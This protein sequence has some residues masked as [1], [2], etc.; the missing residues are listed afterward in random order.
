MVMVS[1]PGSLRIATAGSGV[2][3]AGAL[4]PDLVARLS[5]EAAMTAGHM[6]TM[7]VRALDYCPPVDLTFGDYLRALVTADVQIVPEDRLG[8]RTAVVEA[9]RAWGVYPKGL[10]ALAVDT[11]VWD[12][13]SPEIQKLLRPQ[14]MALQPY[15]SNYTYLS[16]RDKAD[17]RR[18]IFEK[19]GEWR[20]A[21]HG[22]ITEFLTS[23]EA[24]DRQALAEEMGID[25][26][27]GYASF[28]LRALQFT[29]KVSPDGNEVPQALL[30]FVQERGED[31]DGGS[32]AF[33]FRGG[34][35]VIVDLLSGEIDY[36]IRKNV[37]S[38]SR[39]AAERA[40]H[41]QARAGLVGMYLGAANESDPSRQLALLHGVD[42][43]F[44]HG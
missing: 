32:G 24:T 36:V 25:L 43:E 1:S 29:R 34:C 41:V 38:G 19:L 2:L 37:R 12:R 11:L 13:P 18:E 3:P 22:W 5:D 15:A 8:Y 4:H 16:G 39:L 28:E 44:N 33:T 35:T 7:C 9:F 20:A 6:L 26:D 40:F 31:G 42:P 14:L 23:L 10:R 30:S 27:P 17:P 21:L